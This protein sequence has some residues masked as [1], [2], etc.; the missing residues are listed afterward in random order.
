MRIGH[1]VS[2]AV[3]L[4]LACIATPCDAA[5][6]PDAASAFVAELAHQALLPGA[7]QA[8]SAA[9]RQ[10]R[11]E[12]LLDTDFDVPKIASFVLGHYWQKASDAERQQFTAVFRDFMIRTYSQR[13]TEYDS[14]SFRI[15]RQ[16]EESATSTVVYSEIGEAGSDQAVKVEWRVADKDG[17]KITDLTVDGISMALA[18]REEFSSSLQRSGGDLQSLIRQLQVK[19]SAQKSP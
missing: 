6:A 9:E 19:M 10:R 17:Y 8:L 1:L 3:L 5:G 16:R 2:S 7:G 15:I 18:Q 4:V 11:F 14:D 12:G 13:F